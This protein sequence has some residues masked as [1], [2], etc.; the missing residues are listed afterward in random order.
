M[1]PFFI[2]YNFI[3][4]NDTSKFKTRNQYDVGNWDS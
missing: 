4:Q 1:N 3:D 2:E